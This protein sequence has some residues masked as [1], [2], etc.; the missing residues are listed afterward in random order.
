VRLH[1][2]LTTAV[3]GGYI[4]FQKN[5]IYLFKRI[6]KKL[7]MEN[8][9]KIIQIIDDYK[10]NYTN[11]NSEI[12]FANSKV[13]FEKVSRAQTE[14]CLSIIGYF[15][16]ETRREYT[17]KDYIIYFIKDLIPIVLTIV[18]MFVLFKFMTNRLYF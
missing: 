2:I 5:R 14:E 18:A 15:L 1:V 13:V 6:D 8:K 7:V 11:S 9:S 3:L 12:T 10:S 4:I 16:D 17:F